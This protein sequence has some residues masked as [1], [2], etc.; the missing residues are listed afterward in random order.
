MTLYLTLDPFPEVT[1]VLG[2]LKTA[3]NAHRDS[4]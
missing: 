1:D 3:G 2:K 4:L